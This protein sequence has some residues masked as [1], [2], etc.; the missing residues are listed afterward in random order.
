MRKLHMRAVFAASIIVVAGF[1]CAAPASASQ[2]APLNCEKAASPSERTICGNYMLG[3]QEA[4]MATLFSVATGLVPMGRR[5]DIEDSQRKWLKQRAACGKNV[6]CLTRAY[7]AR[8]R[9]LNDVISDIA[10]RG[11]Y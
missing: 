2:Y 11:P 8:I 6:D 9:E 10:S 1:V 4:R 3:Q 7:D 5:G